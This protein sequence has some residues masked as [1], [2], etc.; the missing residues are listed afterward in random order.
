[1]VQLTYDE[2][3]DALNECMVSVWV[4]DESTFGT[5]PLESMKCDVPVVG[6]IPDTEPD[7]LTENGMW[8]YDSNK[9]VEILGTY[10]IAWLEG[11][12]LTAEVK[13]KMKETLLPYSYDITEKNIVKIFTSYKNN[14]INKIQLAIEKLKKRRFPNEKY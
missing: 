7:W 12:E 14:R 13:E 8:T 3:A 4:D 5:F 9:I 6:K 2:F 10:I 1:M 11:I